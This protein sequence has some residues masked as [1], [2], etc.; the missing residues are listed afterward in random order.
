MAIRSRTTKVKVDEVVFALLLEEMGKK[1][2]EV[3]KEALSV[4]DR[5][6]DKSKKDTKSKSQ[7]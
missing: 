6:I 1:S 2:Y 7:E 5:Y 3:A 4:R